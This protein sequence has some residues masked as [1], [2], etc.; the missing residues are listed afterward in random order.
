[1][2]IIIIQATYLVYS[3]GIAI[4]I[5]SI[6][7]QHLNRPAESTPRHAIRAV[8]VRCGIDIRPRLMNSSM[9]E[10]TSSI[11]WAAQVACHVLVNV[12]FWSKEVTCV[13]V[14]PMGT[15]S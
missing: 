3:L 10:E 5:G 14:P 7:R 2:I 15:P 6:L 8:R 12:L 11:G 4:Q 1:M 13:L 9:D